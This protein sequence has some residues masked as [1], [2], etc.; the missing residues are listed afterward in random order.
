MKRYTWLNNCFGFSRLIV[1]MLLLLIL[2]FNKTSLGQQDYKKFLSIGKNIFTLEVSRLPSGLMNADLYTGYDKE[3][4]KNTS[5]QFYSESYEVFKEAFRIGINQIADSS[6]PKIDLKGS[7]DAISYISQMTYRELVIF[8]LKT[9]EI[10]PAAGYIHLSKDITVNPNVTGHF[11]CSR[12]GKLKLLNKITNQNLSLLKMIFVRLDSIDSLK[13][14]VTALRDSLCDDN[15]QFINLN[16][17]I[18]QQKKWKADTKKPA[19]TKTE[20]DTIKGATTK[21]DNSNTSKPATKPNQDAAQNP[22]KSHAKKSG[23]DTTNYCINCTTIVNDSINYMRF[24][25]GELKN[26]IT[27]G[28]MSVANAVLQIK[29]CDKW[30][31]ILT[32]INKKD[33]AVKS[34]QK[35]EAVKIKSGIESMRDTL[36]KFIIVDNA[37]PYYNT[38]AHSFSDIL[39]SIK[40]LKKGFKQMAFWDTD[41]MISNFDKIIIR[42]D[43]VEKVFGDLVDV[44]NSGIDSIDQESYKLQRA[45]EKKQTDS[46][47]TQNQRVINEELL[48]NTVDADPKKKEYKDNK[49]L[50]EISIK[51]LHKK[52]EEGRQNLKEM[53][54]FKLDIKTSIGRTNSV[55]LITQQFQKE[56]NPTRK[57]LTVLAEKVNGLKQ[58]ETTLSKLMELKKYKIDSV[59]LEFNDG[60][61][62]NIITE[63][64]YLDNFMVFSNPT[65]IQFTAISHIEKLRN[66]DLVDMAHQQYKIS[67]ADVM[68]YVPALNVDN[69]DYCPSDSVYNIATRNGEVLIKQAMKEQVKRILDARVYTDLLG[70]TADQPNGLIQFE[71]S[72]KIPLFTHRIKYCSK[73]RSFVAFGSFYEPKFTL[74]KL[75]QNNKFYYPISKDNVSGKSTIS[76]IDVYRYS[77]MRL[78]ALYVNLFTWELAEVK[79]ALEING[80]YSFLYTPVRDSISQNN[81]KQWGAVSGLPFFE[82]RIQIKP[83]PRYG[84]TLSSSFGWLYLWDKKLALINDPEN[85]TVSDSYNRHLLSFQFD[86]FFKPFRHSESAAFFRMQNTHSFPMSQNYLQFQA[87]FAFNVLGDW[88]KK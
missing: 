77:S 73:Y 80:G 26:L 23:S 37:N 46:V 33:S 58:S 8:D 19:K 10:I 60:V 68:A 63:G 16:D 45:I 21:S 24:K 51:D 84:F 28:R 18:I 52:L 9:S 50:L 13:G 4:G 11:P 66:I 85:P 74:S 20:A 44:Y 27:S 25:H 3:K 72:K 88:G 41:T 75:E 48:K 34:K 55:V 79:S 7:V 15:N 64:T 14:Y 81:I 5:F 32:D 1:P 65:P 49:E 35:K 36:N 70:F 17:R 22:T 61:L 12:L 40:S 82:A 78:A 71:I 62:K 56:L 83:D 47:E 31:T 39:T 59:H 38:K 57:E 54:R 2:T 67:L 87:G 53:K 43:S 29:N 69:E 42:V 76:T 30:L 86:A 6:E